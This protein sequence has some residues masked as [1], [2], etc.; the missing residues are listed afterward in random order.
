MKTKVKLKDG[1]T[2]YI[3]G[4]YIDDRA[5]LTAIIV[6][7]NQIIFEPVSE[8][9]VIISKKK[10]IKKFDVESDEYRI[11]NLLYQ[12][13]KRINPNRKKPNLHSWSEEVE[14]MISK[15][16]DRR[17]PSEVIKLIELVFTSTKVGNN[18]FQWKKVIQSPSKLRVKYDDLVTEFILD[19][20]HK[21]VQ[22]NQVVQQAFSTK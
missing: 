20:Q 10:V 21:K 3:D 6:V 14:K 11:S 7:D 19:N 16:N 2:G 9:E 18:G 8:L 12:C 5:V 22:E 1:N 15:K 13:L 17:D 4:Y